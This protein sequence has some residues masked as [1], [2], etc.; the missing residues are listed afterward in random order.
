MGYK[1]TYSQLEA[2]KKQLEANNKAL[3]KHCN[4]LNKNS[5]VSKLIKSNDKQINILKD[6]FYID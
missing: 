2:I 3:V 5:A 6:E 1:V 4:V